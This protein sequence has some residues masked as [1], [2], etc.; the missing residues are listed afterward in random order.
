M[1]VD[2]VERTFDVRGMDLSKNIIIYPYGE[3]G[4]QLEKLMKDFFDVTPAYIIDNKKS[5]SDERIKNLDY[6]KELNPKK[7][8]VI[9][10]TTNFDIYDELYLS[11]PEEYTVIELDEHRQ[12]L[13]E[14]RKETIRK[15]IQINE[16]NTK[17][18][19]KEYI[20]FNTE[21]MVVYTTIFGDYDS[22]SEPRILDSG[23]KY[24][25]FTD[26]DIKSDTWEIRRV[27]LPKGVTPREL[28]KKYK[29]LPH[30]FLEKYDTSIWIDAN[31]TSIRKSLAQLAIKTK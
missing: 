13:H 8:V 11:V 26:Q 27:V 25:C 30:L 16:E 19:K 4:M 18:R 9:L 10:A 17:R 14:T 6:L 24:I 12:K 23:V 28:T 31:R 29:M 20:P 3:I 1:M 21:N 15:N 2:C 5:V 7:Y 22:L